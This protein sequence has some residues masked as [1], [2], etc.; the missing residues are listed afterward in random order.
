QK[1]LANAKA[2]IEIRKQEFGVTKEMV[3]EHLPGA[4]VAWVN[5]HDLGK[6][7]GRC[8]VFVCQT[9]VPVMKFFEKSFIVAQQ[10]SLAKEQYQYGVW[11]AQANLNLMYGRYSQERIAGFSHAAASGNPLLDDYFPNGEI[12]GVAEV[13]PGKIRVLYM[14]T[15]GDLSDKESVVDELLEQ[16]ISLS[17]KAHHA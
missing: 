17:V 8:D 12:P 16:D 14:P 10:Y 2:Y 5:S 4:D 13:E 6:I 7:D 3:E 11:R 15:Y 9:P 1:H